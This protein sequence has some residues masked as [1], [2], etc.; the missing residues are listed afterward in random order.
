M[1]KDMEAMLVAYLGMTP[2]EAQSMQSCSRGNR[3]LLIE[4]GLEAYN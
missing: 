1:R 2:E 4:R 3:V